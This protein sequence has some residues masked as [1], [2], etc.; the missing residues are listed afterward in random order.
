M[1]HIIQG[2]DNSSLIL[3]NIFRSVSPIYFIL[4]GFIAGD[5]EDRQ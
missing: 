4:G 3:I 1:R 5:P 2:K